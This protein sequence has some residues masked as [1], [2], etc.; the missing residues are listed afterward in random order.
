MS[1]LSIFERNCVHAF[2][3]YDVGEDRLEEAEALFLKHGG[4]AAAE[5]D[6]LSF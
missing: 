2:Q 4:D 1:N 5:R 3:A 6:A